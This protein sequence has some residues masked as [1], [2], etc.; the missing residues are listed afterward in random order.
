VSCIIPE[1][2]IGIRAFRALPAAAFAQPRCLKHCIHGA[3]VGQWY[4]GI[5]DWEYI[6]P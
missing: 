3:K 2:A 5:V 4:G 6:Y 1:Y